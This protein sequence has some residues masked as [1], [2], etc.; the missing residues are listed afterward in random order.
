MDAH[1][2]LLTGVV[3]GTFTNNEGAKLYAAL[4]PHLAAGTAVRLSLRGAT[5]MSSSFLNSSFGDLV[6]YYGIAALRHSVKLVDCMPSHAAII[7]KYV[8]DLLALETA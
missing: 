3:A 1:T 8:D 7:K 4:A 5:A 2:I 6:D